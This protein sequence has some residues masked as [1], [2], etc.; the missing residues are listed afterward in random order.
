MLTFSSIFASGKYSDIKIECQ[1]RTFK[2]HRNVLCLQSDVFA[3]M[4]DGLYKVRAT[5]SRSIGKTV[6]LLTCENE[7]HDWCDQPT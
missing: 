4:I 3:C 2:V 5:R 6:F 1:G 7:G